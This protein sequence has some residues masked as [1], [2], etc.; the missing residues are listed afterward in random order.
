MGKKLLSGTE[1]VKSFHERKRKNKRNSPCGYSNSCCFATEDQLELHWTWEGP[2]QCGGLGQVHWQASRW[3]WA[4][5]LKAP[6]LS[7]ALDLH[8]SALFLHWGSVSISLLDLHDDPLEDLH[9]GLHWKSF[10]GWLDGDSCHGGSDV[11]LN[12]TSVLTSFSFAEDSMNAAPQESASFF[13]SSGWMT[14]KNGMKIWIGEW[15][16]LFFFFFLTDTGIN[17]GTQTEPKLNTTQ[18]DIWQASV[19]ILTQTFS[20]PVFNKQILHF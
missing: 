17:T 4:S 10:M 14:L 7:G 8:H 18:V 20:A 16:T 19:L 1:A 12:H 11:E 3:N 15:G 13:P 9:S 5:C 6:Q 2:L